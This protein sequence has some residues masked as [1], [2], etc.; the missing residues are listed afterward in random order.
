MLQDRFED[1]LKR[2]A[3]LPVDDLPEKLQLDYLD[4]YLA[5]VQAQPERAT[6]LCAPH[7]EHPVDRWR[8]R[9]TALHNQLVG[10][11]PATD[12][13]KEFAAEDRNEEQAAK[14]PSLEF[15]VTGTTVTFRSQNLESAHLNLY[16]M[17]LELLFSR[18]PFA[19]TGS[20]GNGGSGGSGQDQSGFRNVAPATRVVHNPDAPFTIPLAYQSRNL[21]FEAVAGGLR[22]SQ[23]IFANRLNVAWVEPYGR[24]TV[25]HADGANDAK[26]LPLTYI[27]VYARHADGSVRFFRDGYTDFRGQF[28]YAANTTQAL[29]G[30]QRLAV[31]VL[32]DEHGGLVRD[33]APPKR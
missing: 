9:F 29:A 17:D 14:A 27:K 2:R 13:T 10:A 19:T 11:E 5:L 31:L 1:A 30:V 6:A 8:E 15:D 7:L 12:P 16:P 32:H 3:A 25:T 24:L 28:D 20:G 33:V 4:A 18:D 22:R 21:M 23:P 26:P